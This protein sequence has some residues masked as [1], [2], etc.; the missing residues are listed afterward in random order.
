MENTS[1][2]LISIIIL[3][4]NAGDLLLNCVNSV[5]KSTYTNF[6]VIIVDNVSK[7]NSHIRCQE[8]FEKIQLIENK[9]NLGYCEGNNVGIRNAKGDFILILNPDTVVEPNWLEHLLNAYKSF[10]EGLYQPKHLSLNEKSMFM[11]AGNMMNIFGFGY[12]REKGKKEIS[13]NI[14]QFNIRLNEAT[15]KP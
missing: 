5:F 2:P 7:D 3:N 1:K 15:S 13:N 12:A 14:L 11:S 4:F 9:E 8:K 6:E 10:G